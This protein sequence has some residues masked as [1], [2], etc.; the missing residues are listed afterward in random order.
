M[1]PDLE[2]MV[3]R[4][5]AAFGPASV[6]DIQAWSGLTGLRTI[7]ERL[8]LELL[9]FRD[10]RGRELFDLPQ[11]PRPDPEH[12]VPPRFLAEFDNALLSHDDRTRIISDDDRKIVFTV[13]G[14]IKGTVLIDGFV[15]GTWKTERVRTGATL[16][17]DLFRSAGKRDRALLAQEGNRLLA[18]AAPDSASRDIRFNS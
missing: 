14:I 17:V 1:E 12:P 13:N 8:R 4:Y 16:S 3:R 6:Q 15:A 2:A 7:V 9:T 10:E 11:A 18:F 5:L